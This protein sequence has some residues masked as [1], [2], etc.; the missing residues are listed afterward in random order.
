MA[1]FKDM[2]GSDQTL[3]KDINALEYEFVPKELPF[4]ENQQH[5]IAGCIKPLLQE[6]PG[7]NLFIHGAQGI[8]KTAAIRWV[9][10]DLEWDTDDITPIYINCW[11]KNTTY[12]IL[13][14]VC[15]IIGYKF[16]Q[17]KKTEQLFEIVKKIFNKKAVVFAFDEVDKLEDFDFIYMILEDIYR[18]SILLITNYKDWLFDLDPRIKS[19]LTPE[20]LEFKP[21][22][23]QETEGIIKDRIKYAFFPGVFDQ[24]ALDLIIKEAFNAGDIRSGIFML[25]EAGMAAEDDS[26]KK[27]GLGNAK[28]AVKKL[29]DFTIK[30]PS[31]LGQESQDILIIIKK[32]PGR[33]I[34]DLYKL[35]KESGG[36][37]TYKTFQRKIAKLEQN[38]FITTERITGGPDGTTTIINPVEHPK[39]LT[40]F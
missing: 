36:S 1:L 32:S 27:I 30:D 12:K 35:F 7:R 33:K 40:D 19:R 38:K 28:Y 37:S 11:Q 13:L 24:Q 5:H 22:S 10:R 20:A 6:R 14:E 29:A 23:Y 17:N 8:G 3:F 25:K 15:D 16:T 34:G 21:Y 18:K 39:K 31:Q 9:L 26:S 4:R 2:L